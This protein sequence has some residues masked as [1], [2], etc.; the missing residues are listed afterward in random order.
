M[1]LKI[2]YLILT[3]TILISGTLYSQNNIHSITR[4][5]GTYFHGDN[6]VLDEAGNIWVASSATMLSV[7]YIDQ[8]ITSDAH[9]P[10]FN[11]GLSDGVIA[12]LSPDG[13]LL[14]ASYFG[15]EGNDIIYSIDAKDGKVYISGTTTSES[16]IA[17]AGTFQEEYQQN[18]D[19]NGDPYIDGN[20]GFIVQLDY[21]GQ[22][23]W[24]S[25]FQ[26]NRTLSLE[27]IGAGNDND[28]YIYGRT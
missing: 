24:G 14:Y 16:N 23:Q 22:V 25:Y 11:G 13:E 7:G 26:G 27:A 4:E 28:V 9:H 6:M 3:F 19:P 20:A 17:T 21:S 8:I 1:K 18:I 10:T 12:K 2:I 5:W 15:G